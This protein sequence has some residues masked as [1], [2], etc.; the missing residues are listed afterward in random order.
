ML[1]H[2]AAINYWKAADSEDVAHTVDYAMVTAQLEL[3]T[4]AGRWW[5]LECG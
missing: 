3:L 1:R 5:L 4:E 2:A